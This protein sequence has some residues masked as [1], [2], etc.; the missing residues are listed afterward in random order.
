[1]KS[2]PKNYRDVG[3]SLSCLVDKDEDSSSSSLLL[4]PGILIRSS[5]WDFRPDIQ[6]EDLG[7]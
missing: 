3:A 4:P 7:R 6:W 5:A 1:M 2:L